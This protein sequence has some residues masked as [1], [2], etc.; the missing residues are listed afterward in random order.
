[1][2]PQIRQCKALERVSLFSNSL[3]SLPIQIQEV[4]VGYNKLLDIH[5]NPLFAQGEKKTM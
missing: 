2:S 5:D 3:S 4:C 1:M